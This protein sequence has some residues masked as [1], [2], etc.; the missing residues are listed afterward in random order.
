MVYIVYM[1]TRGAYTY[2]GFHAK[3]ELFEFLKSVSAPAWVVVMPVDLP[4]TLPE[5]E[6]DVLVKGNVLSALSFPERFPR[7]H[8]DKVPWDTRALL[9]VW[10][11][12]RGDKTSIFSVQ[13][14]FDEEV[15]SSRWHV[16]EEETTTEIAIPE[17]TNPDLGAVQIHNERPGLVK[18]YTYPSESI[19]TDDAR[20]KFTFMQFDKEPVYHLAT[21]AL[22]AVP[23]ESMATLIEMD[24]N[25]RAHGSY[26]YIPGV[27]TT[28]TILQGVKVLAGAPAWKVVIS[29]YVARE[30][31]FLSEIAES[32]LIA[33]AI[34]RGG[35]SFAPADERHWDESEQ[36]TDKFLHMVLV[37]CKLD[38]TAAAKKELLV[39]FALQRTVD[40]SDLA[41]V[42]EMLLGDKSA[43]S[44][45]AYESDEYVGHVYVVD[46][47]SHVV[48][49]VGMRTS[50]KAQF[51]GL[52]GDRRRADFSKVILSV[53][54]DFG[55]LLGKK[56]VHVPKPL[57]GMEKIL[58]S[59]KFVKDA[60]LEG[61]RARMSGPLTNLPMV[62]LR[63]IE[64]PSAD[65]LPPA[66]L[67]EQGPP[68]AKRQRVDANV[69]KFVA[70]SK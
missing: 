40:T 6:D 52:C 49:M 15:R 57:P 63:S 20:S 34:D 9:I 70:E 60:G 53:V 22:S 38:P 25:T 58:V 43:Y 24:E 37:R 56:S 47:S 64:Y 66:K 10:A 46:I 48:V 4:E 51:E 18:I 31:Q 23:S 14:V 12:G 16:F 29:K 65:D 50:Y 28:S 35:M 45:T 3:H 1:E 17:S 39:K 2:S 69:S 41:G 32:S 33:Q 61:N 54:R 67:P 8:I 42:D 68:P 62:P 26:V 21:P 27:D 59:Y 44:V 19:P 30:K 5:G 11:H 36:V 7:A 13:N 55:I